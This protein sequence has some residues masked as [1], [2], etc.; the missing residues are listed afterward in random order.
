MYLPFFHFI[1]WGKSQ[2]IFNRNDVY[3]KANNV[4]EEQNMTRAI[5]LSSY[6]H[7]G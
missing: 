2:P 5:Y 4:K 3:L 1:A 7:Q 6:A